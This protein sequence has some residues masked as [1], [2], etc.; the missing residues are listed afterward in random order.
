[1]AIKLKVKYFK[2]S[3]LNLIELKEDNKVPTVIAIIKIGR[4]YSCIDQD[5]VP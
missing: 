5:F 2:E 3:A 1:M 4:G